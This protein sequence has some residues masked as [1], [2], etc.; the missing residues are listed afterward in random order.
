MI[1]QGWPAL[2]AHIAANPVDGSPRQ[3]RAAFAALAPDAPPGQHRVI[4]GVPCQCFGPV[5][6]VPVIWA[7][8]GGL[9][10][11]SSSTHAALATR[12]ARASVRHVIVPDYRLAPEHPWPA[13][14]DDLL[15]VVDACEG[16]F[17]LIGDSAGGLLA[18][19]AAM[20]RRDQVGRLAL[21]SPNTDRSG[22]STTRARDTD[23]MNS[24]AQD[25]RLAEMAFGKD[26]AHAA[27]ASPLLADLS[28]L[29]PVW[30]T[31]ATSEVL[32]DDTLL[33]IT[34]LR[35]AGVQVTDHVVPGLCHLWP[36]WPDALPQ[37]G[38]TVA[39]LSAFVSTQTS[40]NRAARHTLP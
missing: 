21:I 30:I 10:F 1:P 6:G 38:A 17:D 23:A 34:A 22:L 27:D 5:G 26:V 15:A 13:P 40:G 24:D 9:V 8:G 25:R 39:S 32:L 31:A 3:M 14:L 19:W 7:H 11:G 28:G 2:A 18:L 33:L 29:P 35:R 16:P 37:S 20:R 12:V 36:L 4:G